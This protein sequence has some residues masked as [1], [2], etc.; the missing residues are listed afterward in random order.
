M[1]SN[2]CIGIVPR[3]G[4]L[5]LAALEAD[6]PA[7]EVD[8][9]ATPMGVAAI[10]IALA[11]HERPVRLAVAGTAAVDLALALGNEPGRET[12]VVSSAVAD[13]PVALA[14]YAGRMA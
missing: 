10:K 12:V 6:H 14:R 9:P 2:L 1:N 3:N 4:S 7:V 8:F 11:D 13:Q 5:A